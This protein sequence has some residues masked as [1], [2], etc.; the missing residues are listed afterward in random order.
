MTGPRHPAAHRSVP[1]GDRRGQEPQVVEGAS[2]PG[3][4]PQREEV[5]P[6]V[7]RR[8]ER[9]EAGLDG[10]EELAPDRPGG[11]AGRV[12]PLGQLGQQLEG[13]DLGDRQGHP[14]GIAGR[15]AGE[16]VGVARS[17]QD[18]AAI[19]SGV[20]RRSDAAVWRERPG[21]PVVAV[22]ASAHVA[23]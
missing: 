9:G 1:I 7:V 14:A 19:G 12:R 6:R 23:E 4:E 11:L 18:P 5:S 17:P 13:L 10:Q 20:E 21:E 15:V 2:S 16:P 22:A 8:D 3:Q